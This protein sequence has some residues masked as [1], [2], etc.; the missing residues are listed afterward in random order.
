MNEN[1]GN[2]LYG[3]VSIKDGKI[4]PYIRGIGLGAIAKED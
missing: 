1:E 4:G 3:K 2:W